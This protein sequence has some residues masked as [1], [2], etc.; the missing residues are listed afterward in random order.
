MAVITLHIDEIQL[1]ANEG[2]CV[3]EVARD[4][5]IPI[6]TLCHLDGIGDI[7]AC[8]LCMVEVASAEPNRPAALKAA[9]MVQVS[10]GMQVATNT[11]RLQEYRR[12]IVELLFAEGNHVCAVCVANGHCELQ[13]L[14]VATG[15][16]HV[17]Y[18]YL[19]KPRT[20]D[21]THERFMIDHNRCV[22]CTRCVRVCDEIEGA[23]TW[24]LAGRGVDARVIIDLDQP[25][26]TSLSCT[27]CGK[28]MLACPTGAIVKQGSTVAEMQRDRSRLAWLMQ[29]RE[30]K[31]WHA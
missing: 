28:C 14:A 9:C 24:D 26:G 22:L 11:P 2:Q 17:R 31:E 3:L 8:R 27:S 23:H 15:M 4:A 19:G 21:I 25:W 6:P 30:K 10:E 16:D 29:A 13:D 12:M 20:V 18:A 5:G 7:G 1:S